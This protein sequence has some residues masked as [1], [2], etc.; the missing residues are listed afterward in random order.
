MSD[1]RKS[2]VIGGRPRGFLESTSDVE[3]IHV[4]YIYKVAHIMLVLLYS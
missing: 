4:R 2:I 1:F 3:N